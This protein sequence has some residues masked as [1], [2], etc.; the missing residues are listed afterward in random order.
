MHPY[1]PLSSEHF[2]NRFVARKPW[3]DLSLCPPPKFQLKQSDRIAT[4]GSCFAQ[5]ISRYLNAA[6]CGRYLAEQ[7]H[8]LSLQ[9]GGE[10][11]SYQLFTARYGN[12][13]TA[14]QGLELFRQAYGQ[15]AVIDDYALQDGRYYDLM[16]PNA[17][18][19]GFATLADARADRRHHLAC[20]RRMF[21]NADAFVFTLGLTE[22]WQHAT[23]GHTYPA[24]PGTAKGE[25][26]PALHRFH[27][28]SHAEVVA[29]LEALLASIRAVNPAIRVVLTVS[30]VPLVATYT[31]HN[32]LV[33]SSY[34]KSLLRA[35][36]GEVE[37]RHDFVQYFPSY[38]IISH[39]ASF[40]QYLESDLRGVA[41]RGVEHVMSSFIGAL[42]APAEA[43][44]TETAATATAATA[45]PSDQTARFLDV[46]C[47]EIYNDV[48]Q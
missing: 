8:P 42:L 48:P 20:V 45:A 13:Y 22:S 40:G 24:C 3:R 11:D 30:P 43:P 6:G 7:P 2:W 28:F 10:G 9:H 34:S 41:E 38:E 17:V 25:F 26:D 46:E 18:P 5:H 37:A 31:T 15:M 16:R 12:I 21:A 4:A 35:A 1:S 19:D 36:V 29:D 39:P 44:A 14:R 33:A 47:E 32:V 23:G 27:N